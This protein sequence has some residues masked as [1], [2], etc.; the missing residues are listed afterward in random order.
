MNGKE[1]V[2]TRNLIDDFIVNLDH[3]FWRKFVLAILQASLHNL[4]TTFENV[5]LLERLR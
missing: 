3:L 2:R 4:C 1:F 5:R